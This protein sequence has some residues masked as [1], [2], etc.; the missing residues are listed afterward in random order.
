M[1]DNTQRTNRLIVGA[2]LIGLAAFAY[3]SFDAKLRLRPDMPKDFMDSSKSI[4][5]AN[6][7]QEE[8][9]ARA[10]WRCALAVQWKYGYGHRLPDDPPPEFLVTTQDVGTAASD[11]GS[12]L[13]YWHRFQ[14]VW[15]VPN[16]WEK[17]Y[18]FDLPQMTRSLQGGAARLELWLRRMIG[19]PW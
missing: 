11:T 2:I 16:N 12:R 5:A 7:A 18:A 13:R 15:Y 8:R 10:Y 3:S 4:T 14:E 17:S 19:A 1:T 9:L 6:R